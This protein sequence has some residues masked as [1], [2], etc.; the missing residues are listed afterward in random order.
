MTL[1]YFRLTCWIYF[2]N[3]W[4]T[5]E[6]YLMNFYIYLIETYML[7]SPR[8]F[9]VICI[10]TIWFVFVSVGLQIDGLK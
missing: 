1:V 2:K 8:F 9:K 3:S 10:T 7:K 4:Q 6:L 5:M